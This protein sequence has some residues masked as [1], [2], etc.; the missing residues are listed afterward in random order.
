MIYANIPLYEGGLSQ[1]FYQPNHETICLMTNWLS[2]TKLFSIPRKIVRKVLLYLVASIKIGE[3]S[4]RNVVCEIHEKE[5]V[6][7]L[8]EEIRGENQLLMRDNEVYELYAAVKSVKKIKGDIAEVGTYKGGSS[9]IICEAEGDKAIH[10]FD[11]YSGLP[12]PSKEDVYFTEGL[13]SA[14]L[15]QVK[16]YL[17]KYPNVNIYDGIFPTTADPIKDKMF[18]FVN[19]D[20]DTYNSTMDCLKFFYPRMSRGGIII[21]H[22]YIN[23]VS[24]MASVDEFFKDKPEP[25]L[26]TFG[27]QCLIVKL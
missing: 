23:I 5:K 19:L 26:K 1:E 14:S 2:T 15:D 24:V 10:L 27:T 21:S 20:V 11:T 16:K 22:D 18:S 12:A 3:D 4:I 25:V 7:S 6:I 9:K 17:S 13:L 8:V